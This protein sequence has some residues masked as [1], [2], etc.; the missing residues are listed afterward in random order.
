MRI[1]ICDDDE[2]ELSRLSELIA[3]YQL[4]RRKRVDCHEYCS[5]TDFL[6]EMRGGEYDLVL[7]DV[8]MPGIDGLQAARELRKRD[9]NIR[10]ILLSAAPEFAVDSYSVGAYHYLLKPADAGLLFTLLDRIEDELATQDEQGFLLKN[11]ESVVR[12]AYTKL[13]YVEVINKTI[14]CHLTDGVVHELSGALTEFEAHFSD[15]EDFIKTHRSYLVNLNRIQEMNANDVVTKRGNRIPVSRL[16]HRQ[17]QDAYIRFQ[18]QEETALSA[19]DAHREGEPSGG[20]ERPEGPW[21]ILLVDDDPAESTYWADILR[22]HGCEVQTVR[23]SQEALR[24][25]GEG[26]YACVLLDVMLS[27]EDGFSVCESFRELADIPVIFLSCLTE[28]DSQLK[29]F[30]AGGTDYITKDTPAA[31]FWAKVETRI[32]LAGTDRT[33]FCYGPL[34]LD[35]TGRRVLM[36]GEELAVTPVEF[37]ILWYLSDHAGQVYTPKEIADRI[38]GSQLWDGGQTLQTHMA[39]LR[40]KLEKAYEGHCF[41]E[42][43][44]GQG[45]RFVPH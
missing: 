25:M 37:D 28:T 43:V 4:S 14:F 15:R 24:L 33:Q 23:N 19:P 34:L 6:C 44:W 29:G 36:N 11:R 20:R 35:L 1:A 16:R 10:I 31:L 2:R 42:A 7:M 45:Y 27:G 5:G 17:V 32:I 41:I 30:A 22:N 38:W 40:R 3:E 18:H 9:E 26:T 39:R 13:E 12:I 21:R 8:L